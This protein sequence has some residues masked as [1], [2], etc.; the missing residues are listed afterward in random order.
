MYVLTT[1]QKM[2]NPS[3]PLGKHKGRQ[4][5]APL[6]AASMTLILPGEKWVLKVLTSK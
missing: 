2:Y 5:Q 4:K 6:T 3:I 1:S